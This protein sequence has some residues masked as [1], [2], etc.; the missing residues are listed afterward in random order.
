MAFSK[1]FLKKNNE[2]LVAE[3][4]RLEA[5][6]AKIG[7]RTNE[8]DFQTTWEDYGDKEDENAAEVAAYSDS[9]GLEATFESE[10][11][12]VVEALER[13]AGGTYGICKSCGQEINEA[14]LTARP[15]SLL[16]IA[17]QSQKG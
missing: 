14:R 16:C 7:T 4:T 11:R 1:D 10:L 8:S 2:A 13:I 17:C 3:K 12:D 15:Q 9:L 6:L 5:Q